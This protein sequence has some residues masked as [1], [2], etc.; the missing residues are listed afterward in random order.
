[1]Y[2]IGNSKDAPL[3]PFGKVA[4]NVHHGNSKDAPYYPTRYFR[5]QVVACMIKHRQLIMANK[6]VALMVNYGLDEETDQYKGPLSFKQ[7][8]RHVLQCQFWGDEVILY[9]ISCMWNLRITVL[10]SRMLEEY[11]I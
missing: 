2:I 4:M 10:N 1:M 6:I 11:R 8:L 5:C 9:V 7:Y 3:I